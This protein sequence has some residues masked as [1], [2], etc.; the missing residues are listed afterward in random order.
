MTM[1]TDN[2]NYIGDKPYTGYNGYT[3]GAASFSRTYFNAS[4]ENK[5]MNSITPDND[6][7]HIDFGD[8]DDDV[9]TY[10]PSSSRQEFEPR[11][12]PP[13]NNDNDENNSFVLF[14]DVEEEDFDNEPSEPENTSEF[15]AA[16]FVDDSANSEAKYKAEIEAEEKAGTFDDSIFDIVYT[17]KSKT[18]KIVAIVLGCILLVG[19]LVGIGY[20]YTKK[21]VVDNGKIYQ[22]VLVN[23][24]DLGG[25]SKEQ[26]AK[27]I[28]ETYFEPISKTNVVVKLGTIEKAYPLTDFVKCP[29]AQAVAEEAFNVARSG[30]DSDRMKAIADLKKKPHKISL[31]YEIVA[32]KLE[33]IIKDA[34]ENGFS[35]VVDPTYEVRE[36]CVV[37]ASGKNGSRV[38]ILQFKNDLNNMLLA[39]EED[40]KDIKKTTKLENVT[41]EIKSVESEFRPLNITEI[42]D[43]VTV[44]G[45][46]AAFAHESQ[47]PTSNIIV[48][49]H[50]RG[51]TVDAIELSEIVNRINDGEYIIPDPKL[52]FIYSEP[53]TTKESLTRLLFPNTLATSSVRNTNDP[54]SADSDAGITERAVNLKRACELFGGVSLLSG[55]SFNLVDLLGYLNGA[56]GYVAAYECVK[57]GGKSKTVGG[58]VSIFSSALYQAAIKAGLSVDS[59]EHL[60][61]YPLFLEDD[62]LTGFDAVYDGETSLR[63][64]NTT[65]YPVKIRAE[66]SDGKVTVIIDGV[67]ENNK[68]Y[69][70]SSTFRSSGTKAGELFVTYQ[71]SKYNG[72]SRYNIDEV[73][74]I[75]VEDYVD[76]DETEPAET[77]DPSESPD[78]TAPQETEGTADPSETPEET[79]PSDPTTEPSLTPEPSATVAPSEEIPEEV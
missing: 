8:E 73:R 52:D 44:R 65:A 15:V 4:Y 72:S 24:Y 68:T 46:D 35:A 39:F 67:R 75:C 40:I 25:K 62:G 49:D 30:N 36:D 27:Y 22:G 70:L 13:E 19:I 20:K 10:T 64:K 26:A 2:N 78:E 71:T 11:P 21:N 45:S 50:V 79:E 48:T 74:Y 29:D 60:A 16:A 63:I 33:D 18:T 3:S 14:D 66:Y 54:Y 42:I 34:E 5:T 6:I 53:M 57:D 76:P 31:Q 17:D 43:E 69:S 38:D 77:I 12:I 23:G 28:N 58:G 41:I 55:E 47:S 59:H 37:F 7:F 1:N 61:Y 32:D 56:N 9:K 51:R